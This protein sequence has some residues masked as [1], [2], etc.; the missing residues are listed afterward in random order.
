M[1]LSGWHADIRIGLRIFSR[2]MANAVLHWFWTVQEA[3][4]GSAMTIFFAPPPACAADIAF[5]V[6]LHT[7]DAGDQ[8][9]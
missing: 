8:H 2:V 3:F 6:T 5:A 9:V 7:D 1:C 4:P